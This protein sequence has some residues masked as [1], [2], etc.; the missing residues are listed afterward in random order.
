MVKGILFSGDDNDS[1][2]YFSF[3]VRYGP[4]T[5]STASNLAVP[6]SVDMVLQESAK[7]IVSHPIFGL[8]HLD[9]RLNCIRNCQFLTII[10]L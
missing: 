2:F 6:I 8:F 1:F 7:N 4:F 9:V 5:D 3:Y 10:V